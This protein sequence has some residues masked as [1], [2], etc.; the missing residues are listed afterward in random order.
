M[1]TSQLILVVD[2]VHAS[3]R[4]YF[5]SEKAVEVK[6]NLFGCWRIKPHVLDVVYDYEFPGTSGANELFIQGT[7]RETMLVE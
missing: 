6:Q 3:S 4:K 2:V 7:P 5:K 1:E